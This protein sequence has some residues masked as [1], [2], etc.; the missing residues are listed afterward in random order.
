MKEYDYNGTKLIYPDEFTVEEAQEYLQDEISSKTLAH[1]KKLKE[2]RIDYDEDTNEVTLIPHY[3]TIVRTRRITG[4]LSN[5]NNFN[6]AKKQEV[7]F[8]EKNQHIK[9]LPI[10]VEE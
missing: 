4:Y 1:K 9:N 5:L 3:D 7:S 6:D 2:F 8:R 10:G